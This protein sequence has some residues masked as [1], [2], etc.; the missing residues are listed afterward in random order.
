ME[1]I[2]K[3]KTTDGTEFTELVKAEEH[4][5]LLLQIDR[6][7][8][9]LGDTPKEVKDGKGWV[10]HDLERV[11]DARE[12]ILEICRARGYAKHYPAFNTHGKN[13]HPM[14]II[15]RV[16]ND[17]GGPL[18]KAWGRFCRIDEQ[19]REHQ[20]PYYAYTGGPDA[21]HVCI[22]DRRK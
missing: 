3:Y 18:D 2:T 16:L 4:E 7:M 15:G 5:Q 8:A 12:G 17:G 10:H 20:Q 19:G 11:F 22:E 21:S 14:S 9:P 6:V 1:K 13:T